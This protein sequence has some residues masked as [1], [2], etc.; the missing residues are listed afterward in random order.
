MIERYSRPAVVL[1]WLVAIGVIYNLYLGLGFDDLPKNAV[2]AAV[3]LHKSIGI[4]V[5]GLMVLRVLWRIANPPPAPLAS[6][7]PVERKVS[8]GL[9]HLLLLLALLIPIS[10]WVMDAAW[11]G[12]ATH[13]FVLFGAVPFFHL[14]LFGGA[15]D[16][17]REHADKL[18]GAIHALSARVL[19]GALVLHV[20][21][22][23]KHQFIGRDKLLQRMWF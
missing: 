17:A 20:L 8:V 21:G 3:A 7:K 4:S 2:A 19:I 10:G 23:L 14:P 6:L 13:P 16:A 1:H 12:A 22:A 5:L 15:S 18:L 9:Q 11:K